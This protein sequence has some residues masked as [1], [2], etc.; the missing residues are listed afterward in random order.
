MCSQLH[1]LAALPPAKAL[2]LPLNMNFFNILF[3]EEKRGQLSL[4]YFTF[5]KEFAPQAKYF[6]YFSTDPVSIASPL[7]HKNFA[8]SQAVFRCAWPP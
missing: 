7:S 6:R 8:F 1:A 3:E 5:R 2:P 4:P